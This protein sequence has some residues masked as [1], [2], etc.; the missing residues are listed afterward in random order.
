MH[1]CWDDEIGRHES[2]K[3]SWRKPCGFDSRSQHNL[4]KV[5]DFKNHSLP[6]EPGVYLFYNTKKE[7]L[8]IGK[9]TSLKSRVRSYFGSGLL[10]SRGPLLVKMLDEAT[11][12]KW[13][14][15]DSALEALILEANLIKKYQPLYNSKEKSDKSFNYLIQT[16]ICK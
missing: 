4:N 9:A 14:E 1:K 15:T 6:D 5:K 2:L 16:I 13:I 10:K 12:I 11:D 7:V 3:R 8:Y